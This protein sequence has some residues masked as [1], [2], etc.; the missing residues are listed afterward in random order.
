M[1]VRTQ[2][3]SKFCTLYVLRVRFIL[4]FVILCIYQKI[5]MLIKKRCLSQVNRPLMKLREFARTETI[6]RIA[7]HFYLKT[8]IHTFIYGYRT[9]R[10]HTLANNIFCKRALT[11]QGVYLGH[12]YFTLQYRN[13]KSIALYYFI[14]FQIF[15]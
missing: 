2:T 8:H 4:L 14:Y 3:H 15:Y 7:Q 13:S 12:T 11:L 10:Y 9:P 6:I 5:N 1:Q